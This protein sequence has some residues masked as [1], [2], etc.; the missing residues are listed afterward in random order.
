M[1]SKNLFMYAKNYNNKSLLLIFTKKIIMVLSFY[2]VL[3]RGRG[4]H[5]GSGLGG[6]G[7]PGF[8]IQKRLSQFDLRMFSKNL[9]R[10]AKKL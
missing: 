3:L 6:R 2:L 9:F 4:L 5:G 7:L 1:F 8:K 10:Y